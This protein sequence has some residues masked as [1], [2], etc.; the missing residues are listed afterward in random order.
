MAALGVGKTKDL[1]VEV[2][3]VEAV[4]ELPLSRLLAN[5][6]PGEISTSVTLLSV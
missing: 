6:A 2:V 5:S 1:V 3:A 4:V